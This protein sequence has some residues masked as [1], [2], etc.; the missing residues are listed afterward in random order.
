MF[1]RLGS[2]TYRY[3]Y[4]IVV[5][6]LVGAA[7]S[8]LFAPSLAT[9]GMTDQA[10]FLPPGSESAQAR[11]ALEAAFPGATATSSATLSFTRDGGL[12]DA[13]RA[14]IADTAAWATGTEAPAAVRDAVTDVATAASR[15]ELETMLRS[16]DGA[17]ELMT[18]NL[19]VVAT[20]G[21]ADAVVSALREHLAATAP[22]GLTAHVTGTAAISADYLAAII[23][24][25]DSTTLVTIVL[26]VVILLLIYRAPIA[27]MV[28]LATIA[29]AF[30]VSR[31]VL[32]VLA[33]AGWKVSSLLDTFIVVLVFGV[34]TDYAIFLISRFREEVA[35][36]NWHDASRVTV[37]RIGAVISASAATVI[38]GLGSMAF[39]EFG[40]IQT[41]GPALAVA[42]FVT[43]VAGLTLAPAL[44]AI[45][46]HYLFWP[47]HTRTRPDG[48]PGGLFAG[49]AAAVSRRPGMVTVALLAALLLPATYMGRMETNFDVLAELPADSDARAGFDQVAAHLG[50]G[51]VVQATGIVDAG[52]GADILSPASLARLRDVSQDLVAIEG[53]ASATTLVSPDGDGVVPD[54]FRPSAQLGVM[55]DELAGD[56]ATGG[57]VD[58][59]AL[60]D[61]EATEGLDTA[62]EYVALLGLAFPDVAA[63]TAHR[64]VTDRLETARDQV[65]QVRDNAVVSTQLRTLA[66]SMTSATSAAG[67][68]EDVGIVGDYLDELAAAYPAVHGL[69]AFGDATAAAASLEEEATITAA[70]ELS[71]ALSSLATWFEEGDPAATLFPDSLAGTAEAKALRAR[72]RAT[73]DA[74]PGELEALA[75]VFAPRADDV[76]LPV[77]LSGEAGEQVDDAVSAFV[78]DDGTATR[79]W[80]TT[81]D[82]PY[83]Q[84]AFDTVRRAQGV[85]AAAAPGFGATANAHLGG[86]TAEFADVQAVLGRD[87]ER[88][89]IVTVIGVLIVLVLLLRALVAPLYL[90]ATV[91]LSCATA[92]GLSAWLFQDVRG[93]LG[94]SFYLPLMVFVLLVALGS[95]Y[96]IFLMSRVR[97]ESEQRPIHEGIRVAS[98]HTG[99]VITSAG[100]I[101]AGTFGS[102]ASAPLA[103]LFQVGVAVAIGVLIDTFV[104]RSILVPAITTLVGERAWWPL[105]AHGLAGRVSWPVVISVPETVGVAAMGSRRRLAGAVALVALVPMTLAGL[106]VWSLSNPTANLGGVTAAVVDEDHGASVTTADGTEEPIRLGADLAA[107]LVSGAGAET[108]TWRLTDAADARDGL[109][110]GRYGAVLTIP[111]DFSTTIAGIRSSATGGAGPGPAPTKATLGLATNDATSYLLGTIA[112]SLSA[113]IADSTAELVTAAYVDDVLLSVTTTQA[114]VAA[115]AGDA[116]RVA[117][118]STDLAD[119]ASSVSVVAGELV[120]GLQALADGAS[121]AGAGVDELADGVGDLATGADRV[122]DGAASLGAGARTAADGTAGLASGADALADGLEILAGETAGLPA[123]AGQLAAGAAGVAEGAAG[124][125]TGTAALADSLAQLA[126]ATAGLGAQAQALDDGAVALAAGAHDLRAGASQ[127]AAAAGDLAAGAHGL[128]ANVSGYTTAVSELAAGCVALGGGE[129]LCSQLAAV[130]A[131]GGPL[132]A[133]ASSLADGADQLAAGGAQVAAG[134][135]DLDAG[136]AALRD[137]TQQLAASAPQ[138]EAGIAGAAAGAS[139]LAAGAEE[140]ADGARVLS[141]GAPQRADPAPAR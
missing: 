74:L 23:R 45:F 100:L 25:T 97:E 54:G 118:G 114:R 77:G 7:G 27:A 133:G 115:A 32:G 128:A 18:L 9:Q 83:A 55:A 71:S 125:D 46:G 113:A 36:D 104:V 111:S 30:L 60:L 95:D 21:G 19:D 76:F 94:V 93:D 101:L 86:P 88:V 91:L 24:G 57:E 48:E 116:D 5:A 87:F 26:V 3:R 124:I 66:R 82:D 81:A 14:Y 15:P 43:L 62:R 50:R 85:L 28:P 44:L 141:G 92:L 31:G 137:G 80:L 52:A 123:Q 58:T 4:A 121:Q 139:S 75:A 68:G 103:V 65:E 99:A 67:G 110:D 6:W 29:M 127:T 140:L 39:A 63:G 34:G 112:R 37:R 22:A 10:A 47:L 49:L 73:F 56:D 12:T 40:M 20:G 131:G 135:A 108:F 120:T 78:S 96:N 53:V 35:H 89:A 90:V 129:P 61:D 16:E 109:A 107:R 126:A 38:V 51:K 98:G 105:G 69:A 119:G 130:A 13:D 106:A 122:A 138:L 117:T 1:E 132:A 2:F 70:L 42:I 136:A 33:A 102:M 79:L 59:E 64:A 84:A 134:A 17:L 72:I 41:M 11:R 8:V